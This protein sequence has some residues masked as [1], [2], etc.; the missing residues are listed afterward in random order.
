MLKYNFGTR[1]FARYVVATV[2]AVA[3]G[4][5]LLGIG[6]DILGWPAALANVVSACLVTGPAFILNRNWV[7]RQGG[8]ADI[9]RETAPFWILAF[10][11][12]GMS[13]GG[14]AL[15]EHFAVRLVHSRHLDTLLIILGSC[16]SYGIVWIARYVILDRM[17]F[18]STRSASSPTRAG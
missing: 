11:G 12:L 5:L 7:W 18:R 2:A 4:Q 1:Q 3:A 9:L 10:I 17:V 16:A 14:V 13:T 6:Y 15:T 8:K